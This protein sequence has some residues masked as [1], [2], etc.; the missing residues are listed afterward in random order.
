MASLAVKIAAFGAAGL[1]FAK[2]YRSTPYDAEFEAQ[3]KA[4]GLDPNLLRAI[5]KTETNFI[6]KFVNGPSVSSAGAVGLMQIMPAVAKHYGFTP[7]EMFDPS[8]A[9]AVAA[10]LLAD[11]KKELGNGATFERLIASYNAGTPRIKARGIFNWEYVYPTVAHY[12]LFTL[13]RAIR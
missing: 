9:I 3:G 8:K 13:G 11:M 12:V 10:R 6:P 4:H 7:K 2:N 5:A 1:V